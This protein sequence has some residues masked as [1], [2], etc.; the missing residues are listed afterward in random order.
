MRKVWII[1]K[2]YTGLDGECAAD[3]WNGS[4]WQDDIDMAR[5]YA[6]EKSAKEV[7][8]NEVKTRDREIYEVK[9]IYTKK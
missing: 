3:Y 1:A 4:G 9:P 2:P 7:L 6:D 5:Q 8:F